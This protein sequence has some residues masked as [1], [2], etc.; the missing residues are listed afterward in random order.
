MPRLRLD[1]AA[2]PNNRQP[3]VCTNLKS[4][5]DLHKTPLLVKDY[6]TPQLQC[7]LDHTF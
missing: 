6:L 3:H 2:A 5:S 7:M 1:L 4:P